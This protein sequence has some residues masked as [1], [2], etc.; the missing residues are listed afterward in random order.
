MHKGH[1]YK[2]IIT[3]YSQVLVLLSELEQHKLIT[4][5]PIGCMS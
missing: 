4:P 1:S 2:N 3:V 5:Y